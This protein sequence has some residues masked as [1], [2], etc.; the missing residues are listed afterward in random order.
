MFERTAH[1]QLLEDLQDYPAVAIIGARQTGKTT[2]AKQLAGKLDLLAVYIDLEF[3]DDIARLQ[4]PV[5]FFREHQQD[6]VILDEIHRM[7]ELFPIMRSL[8]DQNRKPG[9]FIILG[10]ASPALL[11]D[12]SESLAGRISY[13]Q[14][15]P[16]NLIE[17][18]ESIS[19][20]TLLNRGGFPPSLMASSEK[21][22]YRWRTNFIQTYLE[23]E[24]P[25]LGL[26]SDVRILRKLL[27]MIAQSQAQLLNTQSLS[28]SLGVTR[29]T[30]SRYIDFMENAYLLTRLEPYFTNLGK[31]LVKSPKLYLSDT[32]LLHNLLGIQSFE[33][34]IEHPIVGASWEGFVIQQTKALLPDDLQLWF[35]RTHEGAEADLVLTRN[36]V[37][38]TCAE[39]K[40]T[41][42]PKLSKGF[43]NVTTYLKTD[44]NFI[45]T[46][47]AE[48][49]PVEENIR[50]I[51][52]MDWLQMLHQ[53]DF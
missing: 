51:S 1:I 4:N 35:F 46:P 42:A 47:S 39:V 48:S 12:S 22:S 8:I 3:P 13:T 53:R 41:N 38:V 28:N 18:R 24:L 50:V 36:D 27:I 6:C 30:V 7:P 37:P 33:K 52:I 16:L 14:L 45:I 29:P 17:T 15:Y 11:R 34:L 9:R 44:R 31:R 25:L 32:G 49:F 21:A 5:L 2:L 43:R 10:S 19:F 40:W 26:D 20:Q 23:R